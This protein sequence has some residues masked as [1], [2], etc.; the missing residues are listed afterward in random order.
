MPDPEAPENL[1]PDKLAE[2]LRERLREESSFWNQVHEIGPKLRML[3]LAIFVLAV[4]FVVGVWLLQ[5]AVEGKK[6]ILK[7]KDKIVTPP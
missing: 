4:L 7:Q 1:S 5:S 3:A 2:A 6:A